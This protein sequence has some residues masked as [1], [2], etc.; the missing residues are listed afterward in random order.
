MQA[1]EKSV[2]EL[3]NKL[4]TVENEHELMKLE[5]QSR[6]VALIMKFICN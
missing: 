4:K 2:N 3:K 1:Y 6:F 5:L